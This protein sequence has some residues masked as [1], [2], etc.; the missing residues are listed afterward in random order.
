MPIR[1]QRKAAAPQ[2]DWSC[3]SKL[4]PG[5]CPRREHVGQRRHAQH[6][7]S[8]QGTP[9]SMLVQK[10]HVMSRRSGFSSCAVVIVLGSSA[11][12]QIGH[13]PGPSRTISG[14]IGQVHWVLV[15]AAGSS[16]SNAIPHLGQVPVATA[17]V[18]VHGTH[19]RCFKRLGSS[20]ALRQ[21]IRWYVILGLGPCAR[22]FSGSALNFSPHPR[23]Q[24]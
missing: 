22:Y 19:V 18:G 24:K 15:A 2:D 16:G 4:E 21:H 9:S 1:A 11:I 3:Q 7:V 14:C 8:Y 13:A 5:A 6:R 23:L 17:H 20:V 10:R 12:P